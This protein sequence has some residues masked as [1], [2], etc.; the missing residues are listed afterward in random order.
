M[1]IIVQRKERAGN[2]KDITSYMHIAE[3]QISFP[4]SE[5]SVAVSVK[6][7]DDNYVVQVE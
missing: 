2:A 7:K 3:L 5:T 1:K 6:I 4:G